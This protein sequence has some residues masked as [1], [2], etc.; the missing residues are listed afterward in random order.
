MFK[1]NSINTIFLDSFFH[2]HSY[3]W[4][5]NFFSMLM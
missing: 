2:C 1:A 5:F 4:S 3:V